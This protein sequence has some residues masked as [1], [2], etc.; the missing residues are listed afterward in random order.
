MCINHGLNTSFLNMVR[1]YTL[2]TC[3]RCVDTYI[4]I[5]SQGKETEV[6]KE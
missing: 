2:G 6:N 4:A 5:L 1:N 3:V